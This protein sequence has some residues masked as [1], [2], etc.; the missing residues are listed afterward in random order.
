MLLAVP[1][2]PAVAGDGDKD[3]DEIIVITGGADVRSAETV[4][5]VFVV[6]GDVNIEGFVDGDVVAV[7]GDVTV[8]GDISGDLTAFAG[9]ITVESGASVGGDVSYG[10]EDQKPEIARDADIGGDVSSED[11]DEFSDAPWALIAGVAIWI[12]MTVS[13]LVL[14]LMLVAMMPRVAEA[15]A[16]T[17]RESLWESV[18]IGIAAWIALAVVGFFALFTLIGIP[19]G[20]IL[21]SAV[22]PAAALGY[23]AASF[24]LGRRVA[25]SASPILA[26][27]AGFGILRALALI[28]FLGGLVSALAATFGVGFLVVA[29]ARAGAGRSAAGSAKPAAR[30]AAAKKKPVAKKKAA[31]KRKAAAKKKPAAR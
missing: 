16:R 3:F 20:L 19:L 5:D 15:L 21:L 30:K 9:L 17:G 25:S 7:A 6:D 10:D 26:F 28:P 22:I 13:L 14:G 1:A 23:L 2:V 12:A 27:L 29:A 18:G 4:G 8:S 24:A 31:A 11:L